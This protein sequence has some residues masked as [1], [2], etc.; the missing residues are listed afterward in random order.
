MQ[1]IVIHAHFGFEIRQI[2]HCA[3]TQDIELRSE[4]LILEPTPA[5]V[6]KTFLTQLTPRV[7][8]LPARAAGRGSLDSA[9]TPIVG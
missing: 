1:C 9:F 4:I 8:C 2:Q 5:I 6:R 7:S 3:K